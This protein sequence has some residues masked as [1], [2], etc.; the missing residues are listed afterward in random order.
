M[1]TYKAACGCNIIRQK[2]QWE[3]KP[4]C[5]YKERYPVQQDINKEYWLHPEIQKHRQENLD[6]KDLPDACIT[7]KKN[8]TRRQL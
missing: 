2:N 4:C 1:L 3:A 6:G 7:C 8:R 5:L